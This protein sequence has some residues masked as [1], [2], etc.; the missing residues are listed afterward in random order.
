MPKN[1][2]QKQIIIIAVV[3]L[4]VIGG[5]V[6]FMLNI[7]K[8]AGNSA[9]LDLTIWGTDAPKA[10]NDM[11]S[12][13]SGPGSGTSATIR[14][15]QIPAADYR[16]QMLAAIAAGTGPDIF[17]I[18]NRDLPQW[19]SVLA[20]VPAADASTFS[21]VTL[22][23]D[24]PTVVGQDFVSG[25]QIYA[26]PL[27]IDTLAMIYNKDLVDSAGIATIPKTWTDFDNDIPK[28]RTVNA[29]GQVTQ[30]AAAL[31]GSSASIA[32]APDIVFLMMLQNGAT[33]ASTDGSSVSFAGTGSSASAGLGAFNFYLQ[34]AN[35]ASQYYT[36]S[37]SMGTARDSFAQGR[38][39][40]IFDYS[41]ALAD[42]KAKSPFLNYAV[43]AMPQPDKATVAVNYAKYL[44][45]AV[46]KNSAN[47]ASAWSFIINLTTS[48][49]D[50]KIY[51]TDTASPPALRSEIANAATEPVMSVFAAQALTARS[52][53]EANSTVVD[54]AL[55]K[56]IRDV[57]AGS[58]NSTDALNEAQATING[59]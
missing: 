46:N 57:L 53:T 29:Q 32:N 49:A 25:G 55:N 37:D 3:A 11:I 45:L 50:E 58:A 23:S 20:P 9:T 19:K 31:G 40:I 2:T 48:P 27:S 43:A 14:Y 39:A 30:A 8:S 47:A 59:R 13:Y 16:N 56:A 12:S 52:W 1:L 34:F 22:Q 17:E 18:G 15:T 10:F 42:I 35:A 26:L 4:A 51:T 36:W 5:L 28:L 41:S 24:F 38:T 33:M 6:I 21:L 54:S 7:R 44:G